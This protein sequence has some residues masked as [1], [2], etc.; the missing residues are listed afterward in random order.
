M[1]KKKRSRLSEVFSVSVPTTMPRAYSVDM[2]ADDC[3]WVYSTFMHRI[4]LLSENLE[5]DGPTQP[6]A[7]DMQEEL[8]ASEQIVARLR[9]AGY[10]TANERRKQQERIHGQE[11]A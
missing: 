8:R 9:R 7:A 11:E 10:R 5:L 1:P 6:G 3:D 4:E 2:T